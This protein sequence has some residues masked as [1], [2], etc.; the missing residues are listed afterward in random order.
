MVEE[1]TRS[2]MYD[3][4]QLWVNFTVYKQRGAKIARVTAIKNEKGEPLPEDS[5]LY[6]KAKNRFEGEYRNGKLVLIPVFPRA[7]E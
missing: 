4:E 3:G 5:S 2:W 1:S 7:V 6:Y